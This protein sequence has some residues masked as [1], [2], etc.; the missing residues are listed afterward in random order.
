MP[1]NLRENH[2]YGLHEQCYLK[3]FSVGSWSAP[4]EGYTLWMPHHTQAR[5]NTE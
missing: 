2:E 4:A 1:T 5:R 3:L